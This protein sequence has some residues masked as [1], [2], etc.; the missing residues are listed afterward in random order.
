MK[1]QSTFALLDVMRGRKALD[2]LMPPGSNRLPDDKRIPVTIHG[3]I[4][5][6]HGSDD[7]VSIEFG[8]DVTSVDVGA[9][10]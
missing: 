3:F 10:K 8:V 2:K 1:L 4:S 6:R 9:T 5:H 7:G